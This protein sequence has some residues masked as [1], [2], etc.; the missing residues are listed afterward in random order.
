MP[1]FSTLVDFRI[2]G[3]KREPPVISAKVGNFIYRAV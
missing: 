3:T 2:T 1:F